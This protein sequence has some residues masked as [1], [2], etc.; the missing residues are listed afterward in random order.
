MYTFEGGSVE[1]FEAEAGKVGNTPLVELRPL[2]GSPVRLFVKTEGANPTGSV[3]DRACVA[4]FRKMLQDP[5][6]SPEKTI[7]D[8]SSGNMGCS[9]AYFGSRLG[10]PVHIVS[11]SKLTR[12]KRVFIEYFGARLETMGTFTIEGNDYCRKEH[13]ADP[14]RWYFLDQLH[15]SVNP[16]AHYSGT[17]PEILAQLPEV[18]AV[19]GS[20]GS[21]GTLLGTGRYLKERRPDVKVI[22]VEADSGTR[23]PGT[24]ALV[25]GDYRTPFIAAGF[26]EG[27]FDLSVKVTHQQAVDMA[28]QLPRAGVFGGL[29]TAAVTAAACRAV[30]SMG[31][32]GDVVLLS[33]DSGWKNIETLGDLAAPR[34]G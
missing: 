13:A 12:E 6:W 29:Q 21:G 34:R 15:N 20:I 3:K 17:G 32:R 7:L 19:V 33:G 31:L 18:A 23:I 27:V 11:S 14:D 26:E 28:A 10:V 16:D 24:A 8:S 5:R 9:I 1:S 30:E 2:S 4:M 25:D 22:A